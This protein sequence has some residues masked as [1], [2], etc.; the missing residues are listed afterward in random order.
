[1]SEEGD[2]S[3]T[4]VDRHVADPVCK[5]RV[6]RVVVNVEY[7]ADEMGA[8]LG[9]LLF[10]PQLSRLDELLVGGIKN[11][12]RGGANVASTGYEGCAEIGF[13]HVNVG[14]G[15]TAKAELPVGSLGFS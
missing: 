9:K 11:S 13:G 7:L 10:L 8:E 12:G 3:V 14:L 1:L 5:V 2:D 4:D 6:R 15:E